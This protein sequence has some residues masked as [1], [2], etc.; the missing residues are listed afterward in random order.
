LLNDNVGQ[1]GLARFDR[2]VLALPGVTQVIEAEGIN[3]LSLGVSAN[4]KPRP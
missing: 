1:G 3:D 2:D 4:D